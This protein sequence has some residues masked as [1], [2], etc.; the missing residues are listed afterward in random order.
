[1]RTV[2]VPSEIGQLER[3]IVHTPDEGISRISPKRS[4]ELLF[5]D[6]VHL[7]RMQYEH[8]IF[9]NVLKRF[10]GPENVLEARDLI[11][12][13]L[14]ASDDGRAEILDMI[15]EFEELPKIF[16]DEMTDLPNDPL[17]T[18]LITGYSEETETIL[19]DPI[20]NFIFTRDIATV[21]NDHVVIAKAAKD[22]RHR[23][24][25]LARFIFWHHPMFARLRD[26]KRIINLNM[27]DQFPPSRKGETVSIEGGDM[28]ILNPEYLLIGCSERSTS[29]AFH[30]LKEALFDRN[31]VEYIAMVQI[32]RDRS[33]MHVDTVFTQIDH[34]HT[35]AY[36]PIVIEGLSSNVDVYT[37]NG[38]R[39][40]YSSIRAFFMG[41]IN[42]NMRFIESGTG[43]SPYQERE[44]WTDACNLLAVKPG[45]AISYDRNHHT[46]RALRSH[47][48]NILSAREFL[49]HSDA[50]PGYVEKLERTIISLPSGELSRARG[51]SHC[52]SCPISRKA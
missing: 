16:K 13:A 26:E 51:G 14:E 40:S 46:E 38:S 37:K 1:M 8:G 24:N 17:T 5:D 2:F 47:G 49:K 19:F 18:A 44:Q 35:V 43:I 45:V 15:A 25:L 32:P 12:E 4:A 10:T 20:P 22:A 28:M 36:K 29:Y 30:S 42:P 34:D 39:R 21:V 7:P 50:D 41:E 48:Y 27:V 23:E 33:F 3:V 52:M 6:I 11:F 9:L 31:V